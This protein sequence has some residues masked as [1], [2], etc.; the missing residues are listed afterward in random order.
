M[1]TSVL[2]T[3][4]MCSATLL[5]AT[6]PVAAA[7]SQPTNI[8]QAAQA[9]TSNSQTDSPVANISFNTDQPS[10][11]GNQFPK[12]TPVGSPKITTDPT[13]EGKV[14]SFDGSS[15]Y[16][17]PVSKEQYA[18]ISNSM[19]IEAFFKYTGDPTGEHDIFS[20]QESG[21]LG[22]GI[23]NGK[24]TFFAHT[25]GNNYVTP[26]GN[27]Q[28]GQW[29][30]AVGVID[31]QDNKAKLY[32]N[33]KLVDQ[34]DIKG[35]LDLPQGNQANNL[36]LGG[37]SAP[38]NAVQ[39]FMTDEIKSAQLYNHAL[40]DSDVQQLNSAA[41]ADVHGEKQTDATVESKL[42]G[43]NSVTDNHI[44]SLNVQT[45]GT[46]TNDVYNVQYDITYDPEKFDHV[47]ADQ[48]LG[49]NLV[50]GLS[51]TTVTKVTD[52]HLRI[53]SAAQISLDDFKNYSAT[54][55]ARIQL[56]AKKADAG[57]TTTTAIKMSNA[58]VRTSGKPVNMTLDNSQSVTIH[59]RN[60]DDYND[61]GII[62]TGDI[63]LAPDAKKTEV[64]D[65]SVIQPYKHVIILTTDG[66]G[67][68]WDPK[69]IYYAKDEATKP[70][71]TTDPSILA[72]R[73]NT[74]TMD[75]FNKQFA[76]STSA[77][78][79]VPT[80]SAQNYT[81]M[82]HGK[83]WDTLPDDYKVTNSI[84][85]QSYF[86]D[87]GK[88]TP[89]YPSVFKVIQAAN[90]TD[91]LAAF[92]E[93]SPILNGIIEPD[94]AVNTQP[95][96]PLKS[97]DDVANYIGS[98]DFNNTALTFMQSDH[99]DEE[100][101]QNGWYD[102][103]YWSQYA[104]YDDLFKKVMDKLNSTG[105]IHD[106]L[107]IA[108]SDHGGELQDHG[109]NTDPSNTNIFLA[110]GGE[111]VDS[112][113]RLTGGSNADVSALVLN[114]LNIMEPSSMTAKVFDPS[115]FLDQT[116]LAKKHRDVEAITLNRETNQF[117]LQLK[118]H[119]NR[120]IRSA[121]M[122]I[123]LGG[124]SVDQ[125][126]TPDGTK[127]LR[128]TV[129]DGVLNLTLGFSKQPT[130]HLAT[131]KLK[132]NNNQPTAIKQAML[133][134][135]KGEEVLPDLFNQKGTDT[136]T[137]SSSSTSG[138]GSTTT[139]S[140]SPQAGSSSTADTSSL[141]SSSSNSNASN[142]SAPT[143]SASSSDSSNQPATSTKASTSKDSTEVKKAKL[144]RQ[145][146]GKLLVAKRK[147]GFYRKASFTKAS[148]Y[149][150]FKLTS[151][152]ARPKFKIVKLVHTKA[153][154]RY[155]VKDVNKSSKTYGKIGYVTTSSKFVTLINDPTKSY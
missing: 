131:V 2:T 72:K 78:A 134:T 121:D 123:D 37:D 33:G 104:Q 90:P 110:L 14:A 56:R 143:S 138:S 4:L 147:I 65:K 124:Q 41:Q 75:L 139:S 154:N 52:G 96:A 126:N 86:S 100:G 95:S 27:L 102:D 87:F 94:A 82:L 64:A 39:S 59:G 35:D 89:E 3:V 16:T 122:R 71:W 140:S 62:G 67:N 12:I 115:A 42:V 25:G 38:N 107:V 7:V 113:K 133:G 93:W 98:S 53:E 74:Y 18:S 66:G 130:N 155:Q 152:T 15:A 92:S 70:E 142:A 48:L 144:S 19:A 141:T 128:Q 21:G 50:Y 135:D 57:S 23:Y 109:Q 8:S 117:E 60:A 129:K 51:P 47:S 31:K 108:N 73:K 17:M 29:V 105:H 99:M 146:K 69:G 43:A 97:F 22:L 111:T 77:T 103:N 145:F 116:N 30:H 6:L 91:S 20:N 137:G 58:T 149:G 119:Q 55:L 34:A 24:V 1:K 11:S 101:H 125:V 13:M 5:S 106:T 26:S 127:I 44:Y 132:G 80:I 150:W 28:T 63:A 120:Q 151:K 114:A 54:R 153:G 49:N 85:G 148:R 10:D 79:V 136:P 36:V 32:L 83:V 118:P 88:P 45:R 40:S 81:S 9:Q 61:D 68:P 112:S 46:N 76:M 84:A